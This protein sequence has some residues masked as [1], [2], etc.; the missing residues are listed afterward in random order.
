MKKIKILVVTYHPWREDISAGNTLSNIFSG[1]EDR[2][3]FANIYV[4]DDKP[5]N[6]IVSRF[7]HIS[8]REMVKKLITRGD[9]GEEVKPVGESEKKENF[10]YGY[11]K[12]RQL[13]WN[14]LIMMQDLIGALSNWKSKSLDVF[15]TDFNPDIIFGPLGRNP[16]SN[17]IMAELSKKYNIPLVAYPWD[18]HYSMQKFSLSPFFWTKLFLERHYI[19]KCA[20]QS[21]YLYSIT[22]LMKKEYSKYFGKESK[23]LYKVFSFSQRPPKKDIG[24]IVKIVYMGNIGDGRWKTLS[25]FVSV[26]NE[27]NVNGKQLS[28]D[29]YTLSPISEKMRNCLNKGECRLKEPVPASQKME[30]LQDADILLHV[31]PE[32]LKERLLFRLSFSTKIVD[33]MFNAKCIIA[34]GKDT[35]T[36]NYL[37]ENDCAVVIE[38][39]SLIKGKLIEILKNKEIISLYSDKAWAC[40]VRNHNINEIQSNLYSDFKQLICKSNE[41]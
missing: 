19:K 24:E 20:S 4:R 25:H 35:G 22:S 38:D 29:I 32:S 34:I 8:E 7:F 21:A 31:E 11:N 28:L 15:V 26:I 16:I 37:L 36:I 39:K 33:Y 13:R 23:L 17:R 12:A 27:L 10:S 9:V 41:N 2:L 30:V 1:M 14:V 18:D 40:G 5:C 6:K 3:E